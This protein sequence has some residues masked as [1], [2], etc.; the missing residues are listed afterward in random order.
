MSISWKV[1]CAD[2]ADE[3]ENATTP[4]CIFKADVPTFVFD[5]IPLRLKPL[6]KDTEI[7][8]LALAPTWNV[9]LPTAPT[10]P[11]PAPAKTI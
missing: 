9:T 4:E 2:C 1:V 6:D 3:T 10:K 7:V 5:A 11:F 8:S